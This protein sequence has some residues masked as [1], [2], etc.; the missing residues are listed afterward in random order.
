MKHEFLKQC[1]G[2]GV[3]DRQGAEQ[4]CGRIFTQIH[5]IIGGQVTGDLRRELDE[6]REKCPFCV[7]AFLKTLQKTVDVY[8]T[9]PDKTLGDT[10]RTRLRDQIRQGLDA[11]RN[12]PDCN[13]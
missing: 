11:I 4:D 12:D 3:R 7:D 6:L 13:Q 8:A 9:L 1:K 2:E 5:D 10:D